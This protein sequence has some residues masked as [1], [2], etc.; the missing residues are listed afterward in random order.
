MTTELR[1]GEFCLP[2]LVSPKEYLGQLNTILREKSYQIGQILPN[3]DSLKVIM[4]ITT[5][6][7]PSDCNLYFIKKPQGKSFLVSVRG[8]L[9]NP[10]DENLKE[11]CKRGYPVTSFRIDFMPIPQGS[12]TPSR[13]SS[14][15]EIHKDNPRFTF[16]F[17][18]K[19][20]GA[21]QGITPIYGGTSCVEFYRLKN[22]VVEDF[23]PN[24]GGLH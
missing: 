20:R 6:D 1:T 18:V 16:K 15:L 13:L 10:Y 19:M 14:F 2:Q 8:K 12:V 21:Y 7:D 22:K 5:P 24:Q 11:R 3:A 4:D 17:E 9:R 23:L